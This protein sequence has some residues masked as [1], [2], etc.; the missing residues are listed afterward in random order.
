MQHITGI[1]PAAGQAKRLGQ[2]PLSKEIYPVGYEHKD[3]LSAPRVVSSYLLENM[4]KAGIHDFQFVIR[5]G[6]W[7][8]PAYYR[9]GNGYGYHICYHIIEHEYGVPFSVNQVYPFVKDKI[10]ALGFPDIL[11]KPK[12][13]Y[14]RLIKE[15]NSNKKASIVV[16]L[17]PTSRP[18][19]GDVVEYDENLQ[20]TGIHIKSPNH[21]H[22]KY[23]WLIAIW[24]PEFSDFI[25]QYVNGE[26]NQKSKTELQNKE[27]H[28][29]DAIIAAMQSGMKVQGIIF[30]GGKFIDIGTSEDLQNA[31]NFF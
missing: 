4:A 20:I 18:E 11:F 6:K 26:L 17:F 12:N 13:A 7:D 10:I 3:D 31:H 1:I 30:E 21:T 8:I 16:G 9:S 23:S 24:K 27:Y 25:N 2:L 19:K 5:N 15:I 28:M 29:G 22:L 14:S